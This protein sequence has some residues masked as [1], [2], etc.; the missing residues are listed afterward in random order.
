MP[1]LLNDEAIEETAATPAFG[2]WEQHIIGHLISHCDFRGLEC[3]KENPSSDYEESSIGY[4]RYDEDESDAVTKS[5][6][7]T[8]EKQKGKLAAG[9]VL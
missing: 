6:R 2:S 4:D 9:T 8:R 5:T 7:K 1:S 3:I